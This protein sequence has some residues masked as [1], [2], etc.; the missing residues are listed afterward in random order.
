MVLPQVTSVYAAVDQLAQRLNTV[1]R[2]SLPL[3]Q[4]AGRVL[5]ESLVADRDSPPLNVSGMDGYAFCI[6]ELDSGHSGPIVL[7]IRGVARAG[8]PPPGHVFQS[9]VRIFTGAPVP[10]GANCVV[11]R[12]Q[13]RESP[14]RVELLISSDDLVRGQNIRFRGEN[15]RVGSQVLPAGICIDGSAMATVASVAGRTLNVYRPVR[16]AIVNT[17]DELIEPGEPVADWQIRDSNGPTLESMFKRLGWLKVTHRSRAG[18]QLSSIADTLEHLLT[19]VD[20]LLLT[21]GVSMGDTDHVPAAIEKIG[22]QIVFHRLPIRPGRPVLGAVAGGK[23]IIGLP[24]NPVSVAVTSTVVALPLLKRLAGVQPL[25]ESC[26]RVTVTPAD[27]LQLPLTWYRLVEISET[28][29]V[30]FVDTRGSGDLISLAR[31]VGFVT[32]PPGMCGSGPWPLT[33]WT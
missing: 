3:S 19:T 17:G 16:V 18:D 14:D 9:A 23:L 24:G 11:Q 33:R 8:S 32:I 22:G 29:D 1:E 30:R 28:G 20:A 25:V 27:S 13:T 7:P 31:S 15:A 4:V 21:G 5:A 12:E 10:E 2:E 6:D 26:P